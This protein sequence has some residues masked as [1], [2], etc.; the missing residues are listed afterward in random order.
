MRAV[1]FGA[2]ETK[3]YFKRTSLSHPIF[4]SYAPLN[5]AHKKQE[6]GAREAKSWCI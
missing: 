4:V 6:L 5:L 1:S 3:I 2:Y